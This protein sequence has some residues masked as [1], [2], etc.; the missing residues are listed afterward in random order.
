M[1][2]SMENCLGYEW[3]WHSDNFRWVALAQMDFFWTRRFLLAASYEVRNTRRSVPRDKARKYVRL[4]IWTHF[5]NGLVD[6]NN[7]RC[8][9]NSRRVRTLEQFNEIKDYCPAAF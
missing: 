4:A 1:E 8:L 9:K 6:R 7:L 5:G 3:R 2:Y